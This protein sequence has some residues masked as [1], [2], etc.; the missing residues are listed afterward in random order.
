VNERA[1]LG[2]ILEDAE[3]NEE[4]YK[5][6]DGS[7]DDHY[8]ILLD[9]LRNLGGEG[10]EPPRSLPS[11]PEGAIPLL[12]SHFEDDVTLI[13]RVLNHHFPEEYLFYRV[14]KLEDE[15]FRGFDFFSSVVPE[16]GFPFP[17]V[18]RTGF[19][20]YL[21]VNAAL[22]HLFG[23][24][25][26]EL[27]E[28]Q[29][30]LSWFLY[31]GLGRLF[32]EKSDYNRYW[33]MATRDEHFGS[34]DSDD[35]L[36]WSG[37]KEMQEGDL[38]FM[39][40]TA[41]RRA[42]TDVLEV[43]G[44]PIFDPWGAWDG[45]WVN[46]SRVCRVDDVPFTALRDDP[47]LGDWGVV[48]KRLTGVRTEPVPHTIYNRLLLEIPE[49]TREA[50]GLIP[51]PTA[52]V[53]RSGQF[54]SEKDFEDRVI[55]PLLRRWDLGYQKQYKRRF[56]FGSQNHLGIVDFYVSDGKGPVTL[57]ENK[58]RILDEKELKEAA[59]QGRSYALMLGTPS[60][61]V[62]SPEGIWVYSLDRHR[63]KLEMH[64]PL[65]DLGSRDEEIRNGLL[66]LRTR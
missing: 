16:F 34:L 7:R 49:R 32:T 30:R 15:V 17:R 4:H 48:R 1:M 57:F 59:E 24:I 28:P 5:T 29:S 13:S 8:E 44:E 43:T 39:Y 6:E 37:R 45:F 14:S 52:D 58:A 55:E 33:I 20:R 11:A 56:R 21:E 3:R 65:D 66:R 31:E 51:E 27:D 47:V 9:D 12:R 46:L 19:D 61:V 40:R 62:A 54:V 38:V 25:Y 23:E 42:I 36:E 63:E 10:T 35:E 41:P 22:L 2:W 64:V 53:G 50:H 18:G 60:F 26:P